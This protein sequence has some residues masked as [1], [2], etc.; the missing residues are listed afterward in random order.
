[1]AHAI[2]HSHDFTPE[3]ALR[4]IKADRTRRAWIALILFMLS[5]AA[6]IASF[7]ISYR[8]V[9][10]PENPANNAPNTVDPYR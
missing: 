3:E 6:V 8:D 7:Y 1:M 5:G 9:P 4:E 2:T 10:A